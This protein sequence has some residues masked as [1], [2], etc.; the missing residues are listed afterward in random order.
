MVEEEFEEE[1]DKPSLK[2]D[3]EEVKS[4]LEFVLTNY[5]NSERGAVR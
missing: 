5:N 1:V 4:I 3:L 2:K